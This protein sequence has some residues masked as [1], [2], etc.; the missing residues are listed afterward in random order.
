[1]PDRPLVQIAAKV[2]EGPI[3]TDAAHEQIEAMCRKPTLAADKADPM[4]RPI[5]AIAV[6]IAD[7][8]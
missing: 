2:S 4:R 5:A 3:L 6:Q 8:G 1:M 7:I